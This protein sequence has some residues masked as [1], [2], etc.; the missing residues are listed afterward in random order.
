MTDADDVITIDIARLIRREAA[1]NGDKIAYWRLQR[2]RGNSGPPIEIQPARA[3][4]GSRE[5]RKRRL[6]PVLRLKTARG[7]HR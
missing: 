6:Y 4:P 1:G 3:R 2:R 5:L 7:F